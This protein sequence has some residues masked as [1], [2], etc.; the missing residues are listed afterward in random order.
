MSWVV[1]CQTPVHIGTGHELHPFEYVVRNGT[2]YVL[3]LEAALKRLENEEPGVVE[4][5]AAYTEEILARIGQQAPQR[6]GRKLYPEDVGIVQF[7]ENELKRRDLSARL[8]RDPSVVLYQCDGVAWRPRGKHRKVREHMKH[9]GR[10][11]VPGSSLKGAIRSSLAYALLLELPEG[12]WNELIDEFPPGRP[13][14]RAQ[15]QELRRAYEALAGS[16]RAGGGKAKELAHEIGRRRRGLEKSIGQAVDQYLFRC[17]ALD[18]GRLDYGQPHMDLL[19][20]LSISDTL[21]AE[22]DL[23][24]G[25][26]RAVTGK[27]APEKGIPIP[28]E[29]ILDGARLQVEIRLDARLLQQMARAAQRTSKEWIRFEDKFQRLFGESPT[30][31]LGIADENGL[32][33]WARQKLE[34]IL[35]RVP[36]HS[37]DVLERDLAWARKAAALR[38]TGLQGRVQ[39]LLELAEHHCLVRMG[40]SSGW[41]ATTV[42]MALE[43]RGRSELLSELLFVFL[44]DLPQRAVDLFKPANAAHPQNRNRLLQLLSRRPDAVGFP[45]SRRLLFLEDGSVWPLGWVTLQPGTVASGKDGRGRRTTSSDE[46]TRGEKSELTRDQL[47]RLR[48]HF[49]GSS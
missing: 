45:T 44:M 15:L 22:A 42:A 16:L 40:F 17:G 1:Q 5:Y 29:I 24:V 25:E 12:Q 41:H 19:R 3:N 6:R 2:Y 23:S 10:P 38:G 31:L 49:R 35:K 37:R 7:C 26:I 47:E 28:A 39:R 9:L 43:K 18:K 48:Q 33:D 34:L 20:S 8:L 14:I 4:R 27:Q 30:D 46:P 32:E 11:Y 36:R 13:S 21:A